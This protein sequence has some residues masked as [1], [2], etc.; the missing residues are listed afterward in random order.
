MSWEVM[1]DKIEKCKCGKGH[2][3]YIGEMNDW[4]NYRSYEYIDCKECY[5]KSLEHQRNSYNCPN[6]AKHDDTNY[7]YVEKINVNE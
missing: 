5:E 7:V 4:N 2:T 6:E 3:R 1:Q